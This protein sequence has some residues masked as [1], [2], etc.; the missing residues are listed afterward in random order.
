MTDILLLSARS[1][2]KVGYRIKTSQMGLGF[3]SLRS[4]AS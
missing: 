3:E 2:K 4:L 1:S